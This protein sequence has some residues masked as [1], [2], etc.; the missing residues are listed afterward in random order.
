MAR[1]WAIAATISGF[2]RYSCPIEYAVL[3]LHPARIAACVA[4][5]SIRY[6]STKRCCFG[7]STRA[8]GCC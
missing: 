5:R 2:L 6:S 3:A 8:F 4:F 1:R 7:V